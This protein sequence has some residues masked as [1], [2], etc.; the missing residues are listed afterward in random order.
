MVLGHKS[1]DASRRYALVM[2][3]HASKR[4]RL[5][6]PAVVIV[7]H[8]KPSRE[9]HAKQSGVVIGTFPYSASSC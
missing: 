9:K 8:S 7:F 3:F 5:A 6:A 2:P 4:I 1:L